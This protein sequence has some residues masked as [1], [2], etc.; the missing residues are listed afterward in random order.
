MKLKLLFL[1]LLG[2]IGI[3][4]AQYTVT[5]TSGNVLQDGDM[6]EFGVFGA[7]TA[8]N[9]EF[10]V[11]NDN[12]SAPI[13]TRIE[14][15]SA[16]NATGRLFE[17][18]YAE[19]C[20]TGLDVGQSLPDVPEV[21]PIAPGAT[22]GVGNHFL[23][24]DPGD[25]AQFLDYVFAFHQYEADGVTEIGTPLTFTYRYN[26][27][28]GVKGISKVNLTVNS[29]LVTG[30]MIFKANEPVKMMMYDTQGRLVKQARF[31]RG[32]Q[33]VNVSDLSVQTYI[34]Q[35]KNNKGAVK[36]TKILVY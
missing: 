21:Y 11:T 36:T 29:T 34:V 35:F 10:F 32:N 4:N 6:R 28:L 5:D 24:N 27:S 7:G 26:P 33:V 19:Q 30:S 12:L 22:T 20:Y 3:A 8:A 1:T 13:Y 16:T 18:C 2:A 17:L 15:V 25:G 23:N 9:Y 31:D 14:F